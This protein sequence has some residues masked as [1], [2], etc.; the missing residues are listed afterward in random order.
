MVWDFKKEVGRKIL[1]LLLILYL[2]GYILFSKI[3][4]HQAALLILGFCLVILIDIEYFR[5]EWKYKIPLIS[6]LWKY[7]RHREKHTLGSDVFA[8]IG[9]IISLAI[10]DVRIAV[11]AIFMTVFGDLIAGLVG[12]RFGQYKIPMIKY[13]AIEGSLA[14]LIVNLLVGWLIIRTLV[15]GS[16]WW[17]SFTPISGVPIWPIIIVMALTATVVETLAHKLDDNLLVPLFA[18]MNGQIVLFIM[19]LMG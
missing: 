13:R 4:S 15:D 18:G 16:I 19:T 1:H 11:A 14:E 3:F 9:I 12:R 6:K 7:K 17:Y 2:F 5:I 8:L 10:F